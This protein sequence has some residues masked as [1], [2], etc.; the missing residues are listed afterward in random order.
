MK[1][2]HVYPN[3]V[4]YNPDKIDFTTTYDLYGTNSPVTYTI[5]AKEYGEF[6]APVADHIANHLANRIVRVRGVKTNYEDDYKKVLQEIAY[7]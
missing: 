6:P 4:I 1:I 2:Q 3:K 5:Y 7:E